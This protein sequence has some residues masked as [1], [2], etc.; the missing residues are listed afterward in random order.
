M[1]LQAGTES[2][3]T[4]SQ[5]HYQLWVEFIWVYCCTSGVVIPPLLSVSTINHL[6]FI[7]E[8]GGCTCPYPHQQFTGIYFSGSKSLDPRSVVSLVW[9]HEQNHRYWL[10]LLQSHAQAFN[11][12]CLLVVG[13]DIVEDGI[14]F[15][16]FFWGWLHWFQTVAYQ[17]RISLPLLLG[18]LAR[19]H[20]L[21]N[22]AVAAF[23]VNRCMSS[24]E[25]WSLVAG[26]EKSRRSAAE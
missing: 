1:R 26:M 9:P 20:I 22:T 17:F 23:A 15:W 12:V 16:D 3:T 2:H 5:D 4:F 6:F 10:S 19:Q 18:G 7:T 21:M 25:N 13:L 14:R 8:K 11:T 24:S